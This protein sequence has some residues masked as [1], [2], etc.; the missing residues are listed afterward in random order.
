[1]KFSRRLNIV[2]EVLKLRNKGNSNWGKTGGDIPIVPSSFEEMARRLKLSKNEYRGSTTLKQ[3]A[4]KHK[5]SKYVPQ[6]LLEAWGLRAKLCSRLS[7]PDSVYAGRT[8]VSV[9]IIFTRAATVDDF[10]GLIENSVVFDQVAHTSPLHS[11]PVKAVVP[12]VV[13]F[14]GV[15]RVYTGSRGLY[16][17]RSRAADV[18]PRNAIAQGIVIV[19]YVALAECVGLRTVDPKA[20]VRIVLSVST[21]NKILQTPEDSDTSDVIGGGDLRR[22]VKFGV[23]EEQADAVLVEANLSPIYV[24]TIAL[25]AVVTTAEVCGWPLRCAFNFPFNQNTAC[26]RQYMDADA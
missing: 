10:R 13:T 24:I 20:I 5:N 18:E 19:V 25:R 9:P 7:P 26:P 1:M 14:E 8:V 16:I 11:D 21:S 17:A 3:W 4:Q 22:V 23:V 12:Y 15:V 2:D 6:D